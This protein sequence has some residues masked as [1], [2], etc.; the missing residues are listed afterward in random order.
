MIK[1]KTV[2][3]LDNILDPITVDELIITISSNHSLEDK[4]AEDIF[5]LMIQEYNSLRS[6][7]ITEARSELFK[8]ELW[9]FIHQQ[10][11]G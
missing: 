5:D 6:L 9:E 7:R 4:T 11:K 2:N 8:T 10:L 1:T 3:R